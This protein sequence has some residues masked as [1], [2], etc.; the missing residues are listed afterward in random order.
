MSADLGLAGYEEAVE[1][2]RGGFGSVYR[3][4]DDFGRELQAVGTLSGH[5]NTV[6]VHDA[7]I[8]GD[9]LPYI[10]MGFEAQG[11]IADYLTAR[12]PLELDIDELRAG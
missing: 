10:V 1:I 12:G 5:P 2:G 8:T 4:W 7:G 9:G 11:S 3:A 6:T